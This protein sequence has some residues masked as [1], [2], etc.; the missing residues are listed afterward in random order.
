MLLDLC[1]F[2]SWLRYWIKLRLTIDQIRSVYRFIEFASGIDG[3]LSF[4]EW[5]FYVFEAATILPVLIIFNIYHPIHYLTHV[6]WNQK[7][8]RE[9]KGYHT[10]LAT[11]EVEMNITQSMATD[12]TNRYTD[13]GHSLPMGSDNQLPTT[14]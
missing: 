8:G 14:Q 13:Q 4:H 10:R 6:S 2:P 12:F 5:N 9:G 7:R 1:G 11:S 3:Y